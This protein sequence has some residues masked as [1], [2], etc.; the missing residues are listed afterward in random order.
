MLTGEQLRVPMALSSQSQKEGKRSHCHSDEDS[1]CQS[2]NKSSGR[3]QKSKAPSVNQPLA[4]WDVLCLLL[5]GAVSLATPLK[6][7]L[8]S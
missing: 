8:L 7:W 4:T 1:A 5:G 6:A 2:Y 3:S